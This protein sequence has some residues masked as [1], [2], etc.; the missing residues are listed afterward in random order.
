MAR[1]LGAVEAAAS[2]RQPTS[3]DLMAGSSHSSRCQG[4]WCRYVAGRSRRSA[5]RS[6]RRSMR[7]LRERA[8]LKARAARA[9]RSPARCT[10]LRRASVCSSFAYDSRSTR[11]PRRTRSDH[12]SPTVQSFCGAPC[13]VVDAA[14]VGR[15]RVW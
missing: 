8:S 13:R 2:L 12:R 10:L 5:A 6:A 3:P 4:R 7:V 1:S 11:A 14:D 9:P 15:G